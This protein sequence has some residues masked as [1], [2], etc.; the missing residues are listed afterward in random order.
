LLN[1][2][3][4]ANAQEEAVYTQYMVNPAWINPAYSGF[5]QEHNIYLNYRNNWADFEGS[6]R[7]YSANYHGAVTDRIGLGVTVGV[8]SIGE[9]DDFRAGLAYAYRFGDESWKMSLGLTTE[10][11]SYSLNGNVLGNSNIDV[12]DPILAEALDGIQFFNVGAGVY[13]EYDERFFVGLSLPRMINARIDAVTF[14]DESNNKFLQYFTFLAGYRMP[15][16]DYDIKL[17]PSILLKRLQNVD[18]QIDVN[19]KALFLD[20]QLVGGLTYSNGTGDRLGFLIGTQLK[21]F[22]LYYSYD[23]S[24]QQFQDYAN[25]S[26]ELTIGFNW[27]GQVKKATDSKMMNN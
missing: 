26:H 10:Y 5:N 23:V 20:E 18:F 1:I 17:E 3:H 14:A 7:N 2:A 12:T 25:G 4:Q 8:E 27:P 9:L 22:R 6:P 11:Q 15:L 13:G 21:S 24:F 16:E 19:L